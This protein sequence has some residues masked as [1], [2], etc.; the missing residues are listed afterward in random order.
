M[1]G[2]WIML[3]AN[4]KLVLR[5]KQTLFLIILIPILSTLILNLT[6]VE[7]GEDQGYE[8]KMN[9]LVVDESKT[10]LSRELINDLQKD[11]SMIVEVAKEEGMSSE[12]IKA[13][14]IKTANKSIMSSF[15]YIPSDFEANILQGDVKEILILFDTGTDERVKLLDAHL[16]SIT[17]KFLVFSKIAQGKQET[18]ND[19]IEQSKKNE[20]KSEVVIL[21]KE[22][23]LAAQ[24]KKDYSFSLSLFVA[25]ITMTL[26]FSNNFIVGLF[27]KEKHNR[28]LKRI[29]LTNTSMLSYIAVKVILAIGSLA[30]QTGLIMMGVKV[31]VQS[32]LGISIWIM[33]FL[34][35]GLG[36]VLTCVSICS[37]SFFDDIATANY[38]GF[39]LIL[40][41]NMLSGLYFPFEAA[42]TWMQNVAMLLPQRW[43]VIAAGGALRGNE[44]VLYQYGWVIGAL[45]LFFLSVSLLGFKS[46]RNY[47]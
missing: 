7:E 30:F 17:G 23:E 45:A 41:A 35:F 12:E 11:N 34:V 21:G 36:S 28:V 22:G 25:A 31:I 13:F 32:D 27:I 15:I 10:M 40:I 5:S 33:G 42:P 44:E 6:S 16:N 20:T 18:L 43:F 38:V 8:F 4:V 2:L 14:F 26:I 39:A 47:N 1:H 29:Q 9:V 19:L 46:R 24:D 3:K 37:M